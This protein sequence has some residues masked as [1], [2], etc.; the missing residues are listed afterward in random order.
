[1]MKTAVALLGFALYGSAA[2]RQ[3]TIP[4]G[5][6]IYVDSNDGLDKFL[7]AAF[8]SRK[9]PLRIVSSTEKA[10]Y[11]LDSTVMRVLNVRGRRGGAGKDASAAAVNLTSKSGEVVWRYT[12]SP[13]T[14]KRGGQS[15]AEAIAKHIKEVVAKGPK[16]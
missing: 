7:T 5:S 14:L 16:P 8:E 15:V 11:T 6:A 12:V 9:V 3:A 13:E 2:D 10:D 4:S 1:M